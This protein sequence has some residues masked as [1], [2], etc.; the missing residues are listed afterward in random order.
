M[1]L[2]AEILTSR[3]I[4]LIM[5]QKQISKIFHILILHSFA[6]KSNLASLKTEVDKLDIDKLKSLLTN[7]SNLKNK[8]DKLDIDKL[9]P[10]PVDLSKLR[11][12]VK[13]EVAKNTESNANIKN[14]KDEILDI[15]TLATKTN[16][17]T[18]INEVK[19][20]IPSIS[21]LAITSTLTAA[22]NE[23][24]NVSNLIKKS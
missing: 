13:N 20:E 2:L 22:E 12:V 14:I 16:L 15:S 5:P 1:N 11:N 21:G 3:L 17:N 24:P 4:Y 18:K 6:L 9:I 7:L 23:I 10:V 19:V 8:V